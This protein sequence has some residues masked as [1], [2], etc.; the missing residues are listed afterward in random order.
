MTDERAPERAPE[1]AP[2][3]APEPAR[4]RWRAIVDRDACFGFAFCAAALPGVFSLDAEGKSVA[5]DIEVDHGLLLEA[6]DACP[7]SAI[8]VVRRAGP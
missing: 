7:R 1:P 3:R 2:E 8:S 6:A 5:R 4:E